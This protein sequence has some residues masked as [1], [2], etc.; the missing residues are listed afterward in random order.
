MNRHTYLIPLLLLCLFGTAPAV[1]AQNGSGKTTNPSNKTQPKSKTPL[2]TYLEDQLKA[3]ENLQTFLDRYA[4]AGYEC[5]I[6]HF[7]KINKLK[8]NTKPKIGSLYRL[9]IQLVRYNGK[10]IRTT[11][12]IEDWETAKRIEKYNREAMERGLRSDNF[13]KSNELWVPWHEIE[14][15]NPDEPSDAR[16]N[17]GKIPKGKIPAS[18]PGSADRNFPILGKQYSK[19]PLLSQSL[20]GKVFY[21]VSGHGGPDPGARG[22]SGGRILCEDEYAYDVSLR[23]LRLLL[24]HGA[25]AYMIVRD[26]NDGIRDENLLTCDSDEKTWGNLTIP[27]DQR[28][29]L[30][31]RCDI[32]NDLTELN[33]KAGLNDQTLIEIHVDSRNKLAQ[34]DVFF[35]FRPG[36]EPSQDLAQKMQRTFA[37]KYR[38]A[39][40]QRLFGGTVTPR[41]LYMLRET[42]T[43]KAVYVELG[44]IQ[45]G[46]DQQRLTL[47]NNRQA[48]ANWMCD[49]ILKQ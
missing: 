18:E 7:Y 13:I 11:L 24:S 3:G 12:G 17:K 16:D 1:N 49:A 19:T 43:P 31:Q 14:C 15:A 46:W 32:I 4:L 10:S 8:E 41:Y 30:Q 5:N 21:I 2:P 35:Y 44:N 36:S 9:P 22:K 28:E 25:S 37:K 29:R 23:L 42:I 45:N 33:Q 38:R 39:Q 20:R 6:T 27:R 26:S 47:K 34:I 48:L 40:S